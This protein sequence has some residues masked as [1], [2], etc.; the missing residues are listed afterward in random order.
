MHDFFKLIHGFD[1][2]NARKHNNAFGRIQI[3]CDIRLFVA[4]IRFEVAVEQVHTTL[5]ITDQIEFV[6]YVSR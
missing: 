3:V 1:N 5:V 6:Q 4:G 2:D